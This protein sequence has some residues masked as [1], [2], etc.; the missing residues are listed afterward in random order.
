VA[1]RILIAAAFVAVLALVAKPVW[2]SR[3]Q[4]HFGQSWDDSI[5]WVAAK[6]LASG[7]GYRLP[8][9]PGQPPAVK[10]PPV[11][12]LYLSI[13]W[14]L[15]PAFPENLRIGSVLQAMLLPM[16]LAVLFVLLRQIGFS[17]RRTVVVAALT[18]VSFHVVMVTV[19]LYSELL[20]AGFLLAAIVVIE[21]SADVSPERARW[22]AI[23]GGMLA[24]CAYLTR[25]A[26]LPL[27]AAVPIFY[28]LRKRL[29]LIPFFFAL[30]LPPVIAWHAWTFTHAA[31]NPDPTHGSYLHEY[32]QII[33]ANGFWANFGQQLSMMS[34]SVAEGVWPGAIETL[35]GL[36]LYHLA[37]I[38]S[39]AGMIR[40][41]R[42]RQWP[43]M[44]VFTA[45]YLAMLVC[46]W[47]DGLGLGRLLMPVWPVL[48]AGIA[49]EVSHFARL[50]G[51]NIKPGSWKTAPQW[52]A[53]A[54]GVGLVARTGFVTT[55][56]ISSVM[57]D[58]RNLRQGDLPVFSWIAEHR[59]G[60]AVLL[61]WKDSVAFLYTGIPAS[62]GL[63]IAATPQ[64]KTLHAVQASFSALPAEYRRG[65]LVLLRSDLGQD[66]ENG[67]LD[68]FR[69]KAEA[70]PAARLEY[71]SAE[72]LV[73]SFAI[74]R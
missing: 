6:S 51:Q 41:G 8:S 12:P 16:Y 42:Q 2:D 35:M 48:M 29:W 20:F 7:Q 58:E 10:Y 57:A 33:K 55:H 28:F 46:W 44:V 32:L 9:L 73:Y 63:F 15:Q 53:L 70:L 3:E 24:A 64:P 26:G 66:F 13:A 34:A 68:S 21:R 36:P 30:A 54:L 25:N 17:W 23:A 56:R 67:R 27:F 71:R 49:V 38:A 40:L 45:L 19:T 52:V 62:H 4:W 50:C 11:Y 18:V 60:D 22:W 31:A 39:I 37:F 5:Y 14:R 59:S 1:R 47:S 43:L 69:A 65:M 61:A 72:G 74:V